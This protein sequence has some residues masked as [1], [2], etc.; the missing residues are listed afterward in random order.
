M[1]KIVAATICTAVCAVACAEQMPSFE[2]PNDFGV[3][4]ALRSLAAV[5]PQDWRETAE[6]NRTTGLDKAQGG[7]AISAALAKTA[8]K[9]V[10]PETQS[11]AGV[12]LAELGEIAEA[13]FRGG[14]Q[15]EGFGWG[16]WSDFIKRRPEVKDPVT[17]AKLLSG[18]ERGVAGVVPE[19]PKGERV[20][21]SPSWFLSPFRTGRYSTSLPGGG[22]FE[23]SWSN[24]VMLC[25][26]DLRTSAKKVDFR[27][28][29]VNGLTLY[30]VDANDEEVDFTPGRAFEVVPDKDGNVHM[31]VKCRQGGRPRKNK[32]K[33]AK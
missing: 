14:L 27:V 13:A 19:D 21:L 15:T 25:I 32:R 9:Y 20:M 17:A 6:K 2:A 4:R 11:V 22:Y 1:G 28:K 18:F 7:V 16:L 12:P 5:V 30:S 31:V 26:Y 10:D 24:S 33:T 29:T 23:Y 3:S 8:R